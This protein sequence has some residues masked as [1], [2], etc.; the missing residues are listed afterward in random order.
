M[1]SYPSL[2]FTYFMHEVNCA[3][4]YMLV[5]LYFYVTDCDRGSDDDGD[6]RGG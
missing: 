1:K 4:L 6:D 5:Q 3:H 2:R